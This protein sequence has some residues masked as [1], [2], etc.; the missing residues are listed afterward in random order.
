M[1]FSICIPNYNYERYL[2][3]TIRSVLEQA[4]V[5]LEILLSDNASTDSSV[6]LAQSFGDPRIQV[7]VNAVN[8]GF[9]GNLDRAARLATG[10]WLIMLSSDD[11]ALP[12]ALASYRRLIEALGP[13]A[14]GAVLTATMQMISSDDRPLERMEK[15]EALW[16]GAEQSA[17]LQAPSGLRSTRPGRRIVTPQFGA[18]EKSVQFRG[19]LLSA[20]ALRSGGG[21]WRRPAHQSR[22]VFPLET[23]GC[24]Q[25]G[26]F[27]REALVR[28]SLARAESKLAA[29][30]QRRPQIS[31][32]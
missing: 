7:R 4:D 17:D 22:Q 12:G 9:A 13:E 23:A 2:G 20:P 24:G 31:G 5:D 32:R 19:H 18:D 30:R 25:A 16:G 11:L 10:D 1:K 28:L 14:D 6:A 21:I 3:S 8:V 27:C 29:G 26:V 15:D